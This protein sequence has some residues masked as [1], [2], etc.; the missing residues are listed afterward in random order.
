MNEMRDDELN[1]VNGGTDIFGGFGKSEFNVGDKVIYKL[2]PEF[3]ISEIVK[4]EYEDGWNYY[5]VWYKGRFY[6]YE[7]DLEP[8]VL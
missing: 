6:A 3:G 7:F 5:C 1:K 4:K 2:H 8:A